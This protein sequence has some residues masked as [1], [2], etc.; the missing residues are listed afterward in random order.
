MNDLL[1]KYK[2]S[3]SYSNKINISLFL[4]SFSLFLYQI[5]LLRIISISDYYHFAFLIV[6]IAL[7]GFGISGSFMYFFINRFKSQPLILLI[8]SLGFSVSIIA[9]FIITNLIPFDSFKIAWELKQIFYLAA[10][11]L[12]LVTP[13]FFGGSFIGYV[14]FIKEKPGVTYFYNLIGSAIGSL[15]FLFLVPHIG[16][17]GII[18]T[19]S[20]IGII[21]T[22]ILTGKKYFRVFIVLTLIFIVST[23]GVLFYF[24]DVINVRMSPYKSLPTVLRYPDSVVLHTV[25]NSYSK[26]DVVDSQSIKSAPGISLK[27]GDTPPS[28]LGITIDG[29]NLSA[30]TSARKDFTKLDFI[31][32]L[33][34]SVIFTAKPGPENILVIEPR[35][36]MDAAGA[37]HF[38]SEN[39]YITENNS[40]FVNLMK[41][42]FCSFNGDIYNRENVSVFETS[43][44]NFAKITDERFDLIIISLSDSFHPISSGAYSLNENYLY[45]SESFADLIKILRGDGMLAVTRW[46]QFPPSENLKVLSTLID[47]CE[48]LN[49]DE[50]QDKVFAFRSWSTLTT[51]FKKNKFLPQEID[52]LGQKV[53]ELNFDIVYY[54][55][56]QED[57]VNIYNKLEKPYFYNYYKEILEGSSGSREEFYSSYYFNIKPSTDDRPFFYDFFKFGQV[58]DI[59]RFFGKSTQPFSG[60]G[61]LILIAVLIIAIILSILLIILPLKIKRVNIS[62]KRDRWFLIYFFCLGFGYFFIEIPLIQ[63]FIL[64][65]GKPAYSFALVFF[66]LMISAGIGAFLSSRC[67]INLKWVV[68]AIVAYIAVFILSFNYVCSF[69][70]SKVLWQ[71]FIYTTLLVIPLGFFMGIPFPTGLS[72]AKEARGEIIPWLWAVNGCCSVV[73][74]IVSVIIAIHFGFSI[75]IGIAALIYIVAFV[76]YRKFRIVRQLPTLNFC[77]LF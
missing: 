32:Y 35:G 72:K 59:I 33:P 76:S 5:C 49:I 10:Y 19:S 64:I 2:L 28:Q 39:I 41:E 48:R 52:S 70:I 37:L 46:V 43:S 42:D 21:A 68:I 13:F 23:A 71:R 9:S 65:L 1:S 74:S 22:F 51:L 67:R 26:I 75:V 53:G 47:S 54:E 45:T 25:E 16:R 15:L 69:I 60:G 34:A 40:Q 77:K 63:K 62:I 66:S 6:S 55:H 7:L 12:F 30:I 57:D 56:A 29:D 18:I 31:D 14:F 4:I 11:Y 50:V 24:P 36:G 27:Y 3:V 17:I 44:R 61:Y 73:G 8:F 38:N 58:P 20:V